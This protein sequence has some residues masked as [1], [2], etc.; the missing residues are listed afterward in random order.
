MDNFA[1][2]E[3]PLENIWTGKASFIN[4]RS[5]SGGWLTIITI[6][7]DYMKQYRDFDMNPNTFPVDVGQQFL[8]N[9]TAN[10]QHYIP[11]VDSAIYI[12]NPDNETDAYATYDRG[13]EANAFMNNPDGSQYIGSVWPGYTVSALASP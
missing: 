11:I 12:P 7:I 2:F 6:D 1:R 5:R 8:S 4:D 9:L 13:N 10:H 3:I